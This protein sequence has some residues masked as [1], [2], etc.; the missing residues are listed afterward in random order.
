LKWL[1]AEKSKNADG[2]QS[3]QRFFKADGWKSIT[4]QITGKIAP[5]RGSLTA[6]KLLRLFS[7]FLRES[8]MTY[9]FLRRF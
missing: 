3:S 2:Q 4:M 8:L 5:N 7:W 6:H 9:R 1:S